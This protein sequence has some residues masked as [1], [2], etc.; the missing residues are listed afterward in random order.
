MQKDII[1]MQ[2]DQD[3][4]DRFNPILKKMQ[5]GLKNTL[6]QVKQEQKQK[7]VEEIRARNKPKVGA[8]LGDK[9]TKNKK[10]NDRDETHES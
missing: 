2:F 8:R 5:M 4:V 3:L 6:S 7:K 10:A 1:S 9:A